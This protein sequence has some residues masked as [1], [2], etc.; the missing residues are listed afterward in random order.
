MPWISD[1]PSFVSAHPIYDITSALPPDAAVVT[2][3]HAFTEEDLRPLLAKAEVLCISMMWRDEFLDLTPNLKMIQS[4]SSGVDHFPA[5]RLKARNIALCSAGG[6]NSR[7][8]AEHTLALLLNISRRLYAAR[9]DQK[10]H[11]WNP[12]RYGSSERQQE[13]LGKRVGIIGYGKIGSTIGDLCRLLGMAVIA[14]RRSAP[15]TTQEDGVE[16]A[17]YSDLPELLPEL[18]FV[19][20]SCPLTAQTEGLVDVRFLECM[21]PTS[22]LV[23]VA[24]GRVVREADLISALE[25]GVIAG[26]ALDTFEK[27][28]LPAD[29]PLWDMSNVLVTP[30]NAGDS[31][32]YAPNVA[33][34]LLRNIRNLETGNPLVNRIV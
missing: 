28:P 1:R 3:P 19:I 4:I 23:N 5:E 7:S 11:R 25:K 17:L 10:A 33:D 18:D 34:L 8:V 22:W 16:T 12:P 13:L 29:S 30:H 21:K 2:S 32:R 6:T 31:E 26:A 27:E 20:L 15:Q 14:I 9:D 24:R